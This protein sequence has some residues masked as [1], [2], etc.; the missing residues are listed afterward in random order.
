MNKYSGAAIP[1]DAGKDEWA[2]IQVEAPNAKA[3]VA[4]VKKHL[5]KGDRLVKIG[6]KPQIT[7]G[8]SEYL[9]P[10]VGRHW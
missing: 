7:E 6:N 3:A 4:E 2:E 8:W 1:T 5:V 9:E 10:V